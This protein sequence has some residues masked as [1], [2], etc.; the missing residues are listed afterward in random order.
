MPHIF[1]MKRTKYGDIRFLDS[2]DPCEVDE[3]DDSILLLR[4]S[5]CN[6]DIED[7]I[8]YPRE[9]FVWECNKGRDL[10]KNEMIF[11]KN[12][13]DDDE[14]DDFSMDNLELCVQESDN[15][16]YGGPLI[17]EEEEEEEIMEE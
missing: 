11:L 3:K 6:T 14:E 8:R 10:K 13:N 1:F 17:W 4:K 9:N 16:E 2:H 7:Q 5:H 15:E 12:I